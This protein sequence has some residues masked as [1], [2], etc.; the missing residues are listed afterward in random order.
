MESKLSDIIRR[1]GIL[2]TVIVGIPLALVYAKSFVLVLCYRLRSYSISF[3]TTIANHVQLRRSWKNSIL[4]GKK[5]CLDAH[6]KIRCFGDG[7]VIIGNGVILSEYTTIHAGESVE[8]DDNV[9]I[10]AF[11]YINDT[12]HNF[13]DKKK[14]II[15]QGWNKKAIH[16]NDNVWIGAN[17][18]IL[19]GVTIGSGSVIGAGA[20]V[21]KNIPKNSIAVG[22]PAKVIDVR[23]K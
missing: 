22:V 14:L 1:Q 21:T 4:I 19:Q 3:S 12:N 18:T 13:S 11:C 5:T 8:I 17:V 23:I 20:V 10:G 2:E 16:I 7:K 15:K 6:V 9:L